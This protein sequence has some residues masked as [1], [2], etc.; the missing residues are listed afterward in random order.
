[1]NVR[2]SDDR[3]SL[4][5]QSDAEMFGI[6][7]VS[8]ETR[9]RFNAGGIVSMDISGDAG[10]IACL[11]SDG[12]LQVRRAA[13]GALPSLPVY[14][15]FDWRPR[16]VRMT[17]DAFVVAGD[18]GQIGILSRDGR[19]TD[20]AR[21]VLARVN[22]IAARNPGLAVATEGAIRV[23]LLG[24]N[25]PGMSPVT[26]SFSVPNPYHGPVGLEFLDT[27]NLLVWEQGSGPGP[28]GTINLPTRRFNR[29]GFS[30]DGP[31][32]AAFVVDGTLFTLEKGGE[33]EALDT[34]TGTQLYKTSW[35]GAVCIAPFGSESL[36]LGRLSE[37]SLGSSLVRIDL[38]T[39]ET[40]PL[41]G[42]S[43][44]TFAL[45][46]DLAG[47]RLY[48]L[49]V[50]PDGRTNLTLYDGEELQKAAVLDSADGEY[51][52]ASLSTDPAK[53]YL[54]SSLGR[55]VVKMWTGVSLESLGDYARGTLALRALDG[56]L[57]SL[58][59]DSTVSLW[60]T[61]AD[62]AFAEIY[63]FADGS[64]AAVM[65]DGTIL[66]S[67]DGRRKVRI[68]VRGQLWENGE[69]PALTPLEEKPVAP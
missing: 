58:Q 16:L 66:G 12:S 55:E 31:L 53:D 43:T 21:D 29:W 11:Y 59:R 51:P 7:A 42:S 14:E 2:T 35:P 33:V 56:L 32:T 65:A 19:A 64:W 37:G 44:L 52:S 28:L 69:K 49:G 22:S 8:G 63:P 25:G 10:Q 60:D 1:L 36:V 48:S 38:H 40:A 47:G 15:R 6:D 20:F 23:F 41:P 27:Q 61:T 57:A 24:E 17:P 9:F 50:S 62:R 67:P 5:G 68:L 3:S 26:E 34:A 30:F 4:V 45:A 46:P 39:G 18:D 54:Y 13:G